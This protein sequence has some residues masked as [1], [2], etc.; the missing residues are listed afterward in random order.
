[1][2]IKLSRK[3]I[4]D[5]ILHNNSVRYGCI[6]ADEIGVFVAQNGSVSVHGIDRGTEYSNV[7][8][9]DPTAFVEIGTDDDTYQYRNEARDELVSEGKIRDVGF[10]EQ[11]SSEE[12]QITDLVDEWIKIWK[13]NLVY[14]SRAEYED[15]GGNKS[16]IEIEWTD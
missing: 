7:E 15:A 16:V 12:A 14:L 6:G 13:E 8:I 4:A 2:K 1:M 5:A 9:Y 3:R 11:T 10:D